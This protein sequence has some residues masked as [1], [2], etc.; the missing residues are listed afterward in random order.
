V[1]AAVEYALVTLAS[2]EPLPPQV[3]LAL[4]SQA[5]QSARHSVGL[6]A[7]LRR[8]TA[9]F[10]VLNDLLIKNA[11]GHKD[12]GVIALQEVL[13]SQAVA[14]ERL[15]EA[16]SDEYLRETRLLSPNM[17]SK[18]IAGLLRGELL[19]A[20]DL[21]YDFDL[22][23]LGLITR[24]ATAAQAVRTFARQ[25]NGR[26]LVTQGTGGMV[27]A[28]LGTSFHLDL[29]DLE[30][31]LSIWPSDVPV[32][33]GEPAPY[34]SGWRLTHEQAK[35]ASALLG[36]GP[37]PTVRY[38]DVAIVAS[39]TQDPVLSDSLRALYLSPLER[40]RGDGPMLRET[41]A[42]YFAAGRN[43]ASAAAALGITRQT[44]RNRLQTIE[45]LVGRPMT[46]CATDL[47]IALRISETAEAQPSQS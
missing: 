43:G 11:V 3:P 4:L 16:V 45:D 18:R 5:R 26:A 30:R 13:R 46:K 37:T 7:V 20:S 14:F 23:H 15:L 8:Y 28:W 38:A 2:T 41:L 29:E 21:D 33:V 40:T 42:A 35:A 1:T 9:G 47:E 31:A 36:A 24:G 27:W 19:N 6:D 17:M 12:L 44:V 25:M 32:A 10:N 34:L 22:H 39:A